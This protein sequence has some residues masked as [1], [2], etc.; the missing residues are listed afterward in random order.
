MADPAPTVA[1]RCRGPVS[2]RFFR[3]F[4]RRQRFGDHLK[5]PRRQR[6]ERRRERR[7]AVVGGVPRRTPRA[8]EHY[9]DQHLDPLHPEA[10]LVLLAVPI[11]CHAL[12]HVAPFLRMALVRGKRTHQNR[13]PHTNRRNCLRQGIP[14]VDSQ[15]AGC[16]GCAC[17]STGGASHSS[18][19]PK[20]AKKPLPMQGTS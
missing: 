7:A 12:P 10:S 9:R 2:Q 3:R 11:C 14:D 15:T 17:K 16:F 5:G 1:K 8:S 4:K 13:H 18:P 6:G 19:E 20:A